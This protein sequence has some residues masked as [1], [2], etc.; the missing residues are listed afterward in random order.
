MVTGV[1][2]SWV[3]PCLVLSDAGASRAPNPILLPCQSLRKFVHSLESGDDVFNCFLQ[4]LGPLYIIIQP[5]HSIFH[6]LLLL[7]K[8]PRTTSA[9]QMTLTRKNCCQAHLQLI[10]ARQGQ[11]KPCGCHSLE[12]CPPPPPCSTITAWVEKFGS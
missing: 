5:C 2:A 9:V 7:S 1:P 10:Q 4:Q 3:M 8:S 6:N 11:T 12:M